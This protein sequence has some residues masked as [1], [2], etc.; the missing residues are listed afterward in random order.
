M[1]SP[2]AKRF[3]L[4]QSACP[5]DYRYQWWLAPKRTDFTGIGIDGQFLHIY[6][7]ADALIAQ[8]SDWS[9]WNDKGDY[10]ECETLT[11]HDALIDAVK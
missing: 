1:I 9:H 2:R 6:P 3:T 10:F 7:D 4:L 11:A 8:I 5:L